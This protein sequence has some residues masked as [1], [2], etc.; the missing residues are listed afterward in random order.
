MS[1]FC[2]ENCLSKRFQVAPIQRSA[3]KTITKA[4]IS[5][6]SYSGKRNW[7]VQLDKAL[8]GFTVVYNQAHKFRYEMMGV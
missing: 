6:A 1:E 4:M 2:P 3:D 5:R 8:T 7:I